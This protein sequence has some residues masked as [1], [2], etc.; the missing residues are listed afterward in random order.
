MMAPTIRVARNDAFAECLFERFDRIALA[1]H[2]EGRRFRVGAFAG[3][4]SRVAARS[5]AGNERFTVLDVFGAL[6]RHH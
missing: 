4:H 5:I 2:A 1:E 3:A 6:R